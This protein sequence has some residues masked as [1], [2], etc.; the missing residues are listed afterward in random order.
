V[1]GTQTI[2]YSVKNLLFI[3]AL[4]WLYRLIVLSTT[5]FDLYLDEA[6]YFNWAKHLDLGYYSKPPMLSYLI[7]S[8]TALFGDG[9]F[10]VKIGS[11]LIYPIT[12]AIIYLIAA[13]LF[14]KRVAFY[15]ALIFFTLPSVWLSSLIISTDVVLL[16]FWSLA[17]LFFIKA[18]KYDRAV[19][20]VA[21]GIASGLG[22]L[23]KYNFIFFLISVILVLTLNP[24][25][26]KHFTNRFFYIAVIL[27]FVVFLPN[28]YWNWQNDFVSFSHT[29][30]IAQVDRDLF[31]PNKFFEFFA[32]QFLVFGPILFFYFWV[33]LF[34][35]AVFKD[36]RYKML[37]L[38]SIV[39]LGIIM[40][41]S[42]LSRS[43]ANWAAPTYVAASILVSAYLVHNDKI[44]LIHYS[45]I[46]HTVIAVIFF[47]YHFFAALVGLELSAKA[48]PYKR[49][50][51]WSATSRQLKSLH[52]QHLDATLL[53]T[54]R[55]EVALFDYYMG[56]RTYIWNP[57]KLMK[58]QYHLERDLNTK[59]G[60]D[61]LYVGGDIHRLKPY[62]EHI[63]QVGQTS[64][65][66]YYDF[67][68]SYNVYRLENF[69]GY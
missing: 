13:E 31:H 5:S 32:A 15:S 40:T 16:L 4:I 61:F 67:N 10:G 62:F 59:K 44:K 34:K 38:F 14:D 28:L 58:N 52:S 7:A 55:R 66:L 45:L 69:K 26:R 20:W 18:L 63:E 1:N 41:L 56:T 46:I 64:V 57:K 50:S 39:M 42:F 49:V 29:G 30:E 43:F 54:G 36:K 35:G 48:D 17:L 2:S 23:S 21:A 65:P 37:F 53:V 33:M 11:L 68:R 47:H 60:E 51:G 6:Y 3:L 9:I 24:A 22:L 8:T 12:T 27:A 19:F 25:Y